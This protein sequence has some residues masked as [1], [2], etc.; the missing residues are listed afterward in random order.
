MY[1]NKYLDKIYSNRFE[2]AGQEGF[3]PITK[4]NIIPIIC[5]RYVIY[6]FQV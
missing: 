2:M 6:S 3:E 1:D 5:Y 4:I